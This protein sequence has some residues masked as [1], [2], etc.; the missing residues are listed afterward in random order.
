MSAALLPLLS[1]ANLVIGTGAFVLAGILLGVSADLGISVPAAGQAMTAYALATAVLAPLL[2][3]ATGGLTRRQA[4]ALALAVFALGNFVSAAA[5]SLATLLA[6]RVLM[7]AGAM[8]TPIAAGLAVTATPPAQR[9][10]ALSIVFLGISL[11]Y[12]V[13]LPLGTWL[14]AQHSWRLP[15][16][17][18]GVAS[19]AMLGVLMWQLPAT[20]A[21]P[22][23]SFS[24]SGALLRKPE[25]ALPLLLT[26]LY[27]TAIFTIFAYIGPVLQALGP[28]SVSAVALTLLAVGVAGVVGTLIGGWASD[29]IGAHAT[30]KLQLLVFLLG[31]AALPLTAGQPGW[32]VVT[33]VVWG[34]AG[35]G[36]M[37]PQQSR[38]AAVAPAK[39]PLLLSLNTSMLYLGTALG[40]IVG[41]AASAALGF[42]QLAWAGTP[43][44]V[45]G[46]LTLLRRE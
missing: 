2:L 4:M 24:G 36:M 46:L 12:V 25:V 42:A 29:R 27:F 6:G 26:L 7:G 28:M 45:L 20:P 38:L 43:F 30:L 40:S 9:G 31:Q 22:G 3:V 41:G 15:V 32:T 39:A 16:Q 34:A 13:G 8:F 44:L 14:A 10:R 37:P 23:A 35:F 5:D 19:L 21:A 17:L 11:S 18:V 33:L 1:L